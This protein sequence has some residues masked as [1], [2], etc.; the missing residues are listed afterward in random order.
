MITDIGFLRMPF[1]G[2]YTVNDGEDMGLHGA[3]PHHT[4]WPEPTEMPKGNDRQ[5]GKAVEV[6][7]KDVQE[8]KARP[9]PKLKKSS[10]R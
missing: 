9:K 10:E 2:W 5:L 8:S 7:L 6:L 4:L 3:V 1:R